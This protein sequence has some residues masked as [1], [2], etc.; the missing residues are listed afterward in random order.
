MD[1]SLT[2]YLK[3]IRHFPILS[4]EEEQNLARRWV[5]DGDRA[6]V[7]R[8]V[9]C[10]LRLVV[11]IACN[12]RN[13]GLPLEDL[14]A[15]GNIGVL[16]ATQN[17]DPELGYRFSTYAMW[18][19]GAAIKEYILRSW[20]LV[21]VG[22]TASQKKLFFNLR[23]IK[24]RLGLHHRNFLSDEDATRI[25]QEVDVPIEAVH[26][27]NERM[28]SSDVSLDAP[29][30]VGG[31]SVSHSLMTE[32]VMEDDYADWD[33]MNRRSCYLR[34][35]FATLNEREREIVQQRWF[36]EPPATLESLGHHYG[37][38]RERVRQIETR[39]FTKLRRT[40]RHQQKE[41]QYKVKESPVL[42]S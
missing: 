15:H 11:K 28:S 8:L 20:S 22:T 12:H 18:W 37:I 29:P 14:I 42:E 36:C 4:R 7:N 27:M 35:G 1:D 9:E 31:R 33:E 32:D 21:K 40:I 10:H 6:A 30:P 2:F 34:E 39:A 26:Q 23:S 17:F 3:R 19:I 25:A 24:A 5:K 41:K 13:Y 38:S 16:Q